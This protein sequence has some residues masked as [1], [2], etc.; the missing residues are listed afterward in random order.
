MLKTL[1]ENVK[2]DTLWFYVSTLL[3]TCIVLA[4]VLGDLLRTDALYTGSISF[5]WVMTG[6]ACFIGASIHLPI[7]GYMYDA[8]SP[9]PAVKLLIATIFGSLVY[10]GIIAI[11]NDFIFDH[12]MDCAFLIFAPILISV[13]WLMLM[14]ALASRVCIDCMITKMGNETFGFLYMC[15]ALLMLIIFITTADVMIPGDDAWKFKIL[16]IMFF[17]SMAASLLIRPEKDD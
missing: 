7:G 2:R 3:L 15:A 1:F 6:V 11:E 8:Q 12:V 9:T 4:G 10:T 16:A 17:A 14:M 13:V 5:P